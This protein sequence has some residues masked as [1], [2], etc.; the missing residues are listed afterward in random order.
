[1]V[2]RPPHTVTI[3]KIVSANSWPSG[4]ERPASCRHKMMVA[5]QSKGR[6]VLGTEFSFSGPGSIT[7]GIFLCR[8]LTVAATKIS[9]CS[10]ILSSTHFSRFR[11]SLLLAR[12]ARSITKGKGCR[13]TN[14]V[15]I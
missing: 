8:N 1:M 3:V 14:R 15:S 9:P 10:L 2:N 11:Y 12:I 4:M 6:V 5:R 13:V 7:A